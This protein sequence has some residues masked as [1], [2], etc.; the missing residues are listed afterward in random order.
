MLNNVILGIGLNAFEDGDVGP[1]EP[2]DQLYVEPVPAAE[3]NLLVV[4][5]NAAVEERDFIESSVALSSDLADTQTLIATEETLERIS[6]SME[7]YVAAGKISPEVAQLLHGELSHALESI[8]GDISAINGGL[9]SFDDAE[10]TLAFFGAGLEALNN[11]K[12]TIGSKIANAI[13]NANLSVMRHLETTGSRFSRLR[14]DANA[15]I[16][17]AKSAT[18]S[19]TVK[20][21]NKFLATKKNAAST[22]LAGDLSQFTGFVND[23]VSGYINKAAAFA[24]N[25]VAGAMSKMKTVTTLAEAKSVVDGLQ[26][27]PY[28]GATVVVKETPKFAL[29]RTEVTLGG[30]AVFDLRYKASQGD[31]VNEITSQV[32]TITMNRLNLKRAK[33]EKGGKVVFEAELT[34]ADAAKIA[35][36]VV[37]CCD[38]ANNI[39]RNMRWSTGFGDKVRAHVKALEMSIN[40]TDNNAEKGVGAVIYTICKLPEQYINAMSHLVLEVPDAVNNVCTA[41]LKVAS[42]A[43]KGG[44]SSSSEE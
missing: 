12:G 24:N 17:E 22:N 6:A 36:E 23:L 16:T 15:I 14:N 38:A 5:R 28:P 21:S 33:D 13:I 1:T 44:S 19:R 32:K 4:E 11:T 25:Q 20:V 2:V 8:G 37:K 42:Q 18:G 34:P 29:K 3:A 7:S 10:A 27:P 40:G 26:P 41:A 31:T 9:E 30:Y 35:G 43:A 39:I